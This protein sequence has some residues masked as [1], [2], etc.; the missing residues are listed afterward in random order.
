L[1]EIAGAR[2][3]PLGAGEAG[4]GEAPIDDQRVAVDIAGIGR[5]QEG[6]RRRDLLRFG[7][8][9]LGNALQP[10]PPVLFAVQP[11]DERRVDRPGARQLTRTPR[12]A[13]SVAMTSVIVFTPALEAP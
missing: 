6:D 2:P 5:Q 11:G 4:H 10:D 9:A 13:S 8:A 1:G 3:S 12:E 7:V